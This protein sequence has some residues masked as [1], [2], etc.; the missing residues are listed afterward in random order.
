MP[1]KISVFLNHKC[2]WPKY[3]GYHRNHF[4]LDNFCTAELELSALLSCSPK[5]G[6]L[7]Q[8]E[9]VGSR[10]RQ[11]QAVICLSLSSFMTSL[12]VAGYWFWFVFLQIC[13]W[14][15]PPSLSQTRHYC[16][17]SIVRLSRT[18]LDLWSVHLCWDQ[19][20]AAYCQQCPI[21]LSQGCRFIWVFSYSCLQSFCVATPFHSQVVLISFLQDFDVPCYDSLHP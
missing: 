10:G 4:H 20:I 6:R 11:A 5:A 14:M 13:E 7:Y 15:L 9:W 21:L 18:A 16:L 8:G 1:L 19:T 2:I 17:G 12:S 3:L